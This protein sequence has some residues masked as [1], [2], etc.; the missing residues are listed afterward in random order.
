MGPGLEPGSVWVQ[1][2]PGSPNL[3]QVRNVSLTGFRL[4]SMSSISS[5]QTMV[6]KAL[7]FSSWSN[8]QAWG[9]EVDRQGYEGGSEH[10]D[11]T[12]R[13]ITGIY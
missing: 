5:K 6:R 13:I 4:F 8:R 1:G 3:G 2:K 12:L 10:P 7:F 11:T 9:W